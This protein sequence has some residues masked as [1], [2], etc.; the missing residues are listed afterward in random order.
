MESFHSI[1]KIVI[2]KIWW[3]STSNLKESI[4]E[5]DPIIELNS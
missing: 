1:D 3:H 5:L 2:M 4:G